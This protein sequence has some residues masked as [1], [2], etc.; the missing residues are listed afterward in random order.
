MCGVANICAGDGRHRRRG[1]DTDLDGQPA[2]VI[3]ARMDGVDG[4]ARVVRGS[5]QKMSSALGVFNA[6]KSVTPCESQAK[7]PISPITTLFGTL[8]ILPCSSAYF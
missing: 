2:K 3:K 4:M 7:V 8:T 5:R 6:A 1:H